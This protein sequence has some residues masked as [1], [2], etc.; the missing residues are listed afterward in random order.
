MKERGKGQNESERGAVL[1]VVILLIAT[2]SV[3]SLAVVQTVSDSYRQSAQVSARS[4][5][6]WFATGAEDIARTKLSEALTL[7]EGKITRATPGIGEPIIFPL[8]GGQMTARLE[9]HSNCFNLNS[10]TQTDDALQQTGAINARLFYR[11]LLV[12]IDIDESLATQLTDAAADWIDSDTRPRVSGAETSYYASLTKPYR[13]ADTFMVT[14]QELL[15]VRGYSAE[16]YRRVRPFVCALP[17]DRIGA[18]NVNTIRPEQGALLVPVFSALISPE[19][20]Q[21][22]LFA[23]QN[24]AF[25]D[26]AGF[27]SLSA[28]SIV[29]PEKRLDSLLT[30]QSSYFRLTGEVVYLD[31]VSSYEAVFELDKAGNVSLVRRR[32]GVDE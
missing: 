4:Q 31:T 30:V 16:I 8:E 32:L 18:F 21:S 22:E 3:I 15:A 2:L 10:L 25:N 23:I 5:S 17:T 12:A 28:F 20:I 11:Q 1:L 26:P 24:D 19:T 13:A 7:L 27:T 14:P 6:L 29:T 9:D